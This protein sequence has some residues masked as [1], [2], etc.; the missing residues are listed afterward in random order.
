MAKGVLTVFDQIYGVDVSNFDMKDVKARLAFDET[1]EAVELVVNGGDGEYY[2]EAVYYVDSE[3]EGFSDAFY[4]T[5][6][7]EMDLREILEDYY[8][9]FKGE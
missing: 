8:E 1:G 4:E 2:Y 7:D 5:V 9:Q 3:E 6:K